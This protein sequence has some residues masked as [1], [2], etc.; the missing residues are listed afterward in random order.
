MGEWNRSVNAEGKSVP[1]PHEI[2]KETPR[3]PSIPRH[4]SCW[5][6]QIR[7]IGLKLDETTMEL[8][9]MRSLSLAI[10]NIR[11]AGCAL[12]V[13]VEK[14]WKTIYVDGVLCERA[15][16]ERGGEHTIQFRA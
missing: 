1:L 3:F 14:N 15:C 12:T 13:E 9:P 10:R 5:E 2:A 11:L 7:L 8:K 6:L 16:F 4:K